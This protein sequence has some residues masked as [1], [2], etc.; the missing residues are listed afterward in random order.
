MK[1]VE[2]WGGSGV[3]LNYRCGEYLLIVVAQML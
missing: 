3:V 1:E 2:E